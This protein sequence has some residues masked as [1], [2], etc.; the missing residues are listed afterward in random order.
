[1]LVDVVCEPPP[2]LRDNTLVKLTDR[3]WIPGNDGVFQETGLLEIRGRLVLL[4][5]SD[6]ECGYQGS[7][8]VRQDGA[9][10]VVG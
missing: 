4:L 2:G 7:R 9:G 1:M 6:L 8:G 3:L 10:C 5:L